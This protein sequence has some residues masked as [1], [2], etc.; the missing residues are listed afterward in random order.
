VA[1]CPRVLG[2]DDAD[3]F[4]QWISELAGAGVPPELARR[5][6]VMPRLTSV[7]DIVEIAYATGR[8]LEVVMA[9]Y[10]EIGSRV[11]LAWLRERI[12]ELPRADRW[13]ALARAAL[14]DDIYSLNSELTQQVLANAPEGADADSALSAWRERNGPAVERVLAM[15]DDIRASGIYDTTTLP[16]AL[17][18][19]RNLIRGAA[20]SS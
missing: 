18:E 1:A 3:A 2:D 6:A 15:L 10:F 7:F 11:A 12:L 4:N 16:V 14:R 19:I 13:Q 5:T 9:T 8:R 17:R 20:A